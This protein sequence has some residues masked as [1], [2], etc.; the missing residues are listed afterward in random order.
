MDRINLKLVGAFAA[1]L[2]TYELILDIPRLYNIWREWDAQSDDYGPC[3]RGHRG[4]YRTPV[5]QYDCSADG[6]SS[7][8]EQERGSFTKMP[9]T[10]IDYI[11][12]RDW[13]ILEMCAGNGFNHQRLKEAG[14]DSIAFDFFENSQFEVQ[15]ASNGTVEA[16]HPDRTLLLN[17]AINS[18][19]CLEAYT[20]NR[21][22][23]GGYGTI[24]RFDKKDIILNMAEP[25]EITVAYISNGAGDED[26]G[27]ELMMR[28]DSSYM[29]ARGWILKDV[30]FSS[31]EGSRWNSRFHVFQV[32]ER[33]VHSW[34]S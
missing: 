32:W 4:S 28:P 33:P 8:S 23:L 1:G 14:V 25:K 10:L 24:C 13:K 26:N 12:A 3:P 18:K 17:T 34:V 19:E 9:N 11:K 21:V 27:V 31:R 20:G 5:I 16:D 6:E 15:S 22:I 29:K 2:L 30:V 7:L